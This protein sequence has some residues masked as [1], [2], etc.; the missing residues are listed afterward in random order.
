MAQPNQPL[1]SAPI[2]LIPASLLFGFAIVE[3]SLNLFGHNIPL[4]NVF[5]RQLLDWAVVL[6]MFEIALTLRQ[7]LEQQLTGGSGG[8]Q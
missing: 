5:P 2:L 7:M 8:G 1:Y 6:L 4:I 3:K